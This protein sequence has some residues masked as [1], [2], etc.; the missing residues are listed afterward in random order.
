MTGAAAATQQRA[1]PWRALGGVRDLVVGSL[2]CLTP[3]TALLA[4]GWITRRMRYLVDQQWGGSG[5]PPGWFLGQPGAGVLPTLLGGLAANIKV[6]FRT[7]LGLFVLTLPFTLAWLGAW[8]AGWE[9]SFNKGYEQAAVGP[10]VWAIATLLS[11]P[12]LAHLH[13]ALAH[14]AA[15]DRIGAYVEWRRIRSVAAAAGWRLAWLGILSVLV[16]FLLFAQRVFPVFIEGVV[17][18]FA[19]MTVSQQASVAGQI[20]L[21]AA[22]LAF[23]TTVF[24]RHRAAM[25]YAIAA[26]RAAMGRFADLWV[27]HR[28]QSVPVSGPVPRRIASL[29]WLGAACVIWLAVPV[30]IVA[31]QFMNYDLMHWILHPVFTLPWAG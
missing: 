23:A 21:V 22:I 12:I 3:I 18:G 28:A 15:E 9:N 17:P 6:G 2:L 25:I 16:S 13:L 20:D 24:L 27:G 11:L 4:L 19:D 30:L 5:A 26:P 7:A 31:G 14:A 10:G 8:W 29:L 1:W